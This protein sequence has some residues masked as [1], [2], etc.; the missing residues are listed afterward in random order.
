MAKTAFLDR[1][2][3]A[4]GLRALK[5][6]EAGAYLNESGDLSIPLTPCEPSEDQRRARRILDNWH[7][8]DTFGLVRQAVRECHADS[9]FNEGTAIAIAAQDAENAAHFPDGEPTK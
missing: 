3:R 5:V 9:E 8:G 2:D 6:L 7:L 4:V 1:Q